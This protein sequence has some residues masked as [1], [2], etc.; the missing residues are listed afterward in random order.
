MYGKK[1]IWILPV[2]LILGLL[3]SFSAS[4]EEEE[5]SRIH[6]KILS[7]PELETYDFNLDDFAEGEEKT[8]GAEDKEIKVKRENDK[9]TVTLS[10]DQ[11]TKEYEI[12]QD[13]EIMIFNGSTLI[14]KGGDP[15]K[16]I[17]TII[18]DDGSTGFTLKKGIQIRPHLLALDILPLA[19]KGIDIDIDEKLAEIEIDLDEKLKILGEKT[20]DFNIIIAKKEEDLVDLE[21]K[22]SHLA[23]DLHITVEASKVEKVLYRCPKGDATLWIDKDSDKESYIC[24]NDGEAMV[25]EK[26]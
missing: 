16:K 24:P 9:L 2:L 17:I 7:T 8:F 26:E 25:R 13:E 11:E 15:K 21:E 3:L 10:K 18:K 4:Q 14:M 6:I 1:F 5:K 22:L 19:L 12:D 20:K 23:E